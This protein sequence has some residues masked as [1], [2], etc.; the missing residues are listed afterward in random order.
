MDDSMIIDLYWRRDEEAITQTAQK[1]GS[2]CHGI[3]FNILHCHEDAEECVNDTY[4]HAWASIPPERPCRFKT[5]LGTVTRNL[6]INLWKKNHAQKRYDEFTVLLNELDDC[7]P[8][9]ES[10]EQTVDTKALGECID[11]WLSELPEADRH[12]FL[13]RYWY[14]ETV[15]TIARTKGLSANALTQKL[16]RMRSSLKRHLEKEG[17]EIS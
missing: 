3:S 2:Y 11:N 10:I 8:S 13:R 12:L 17:V 1:Y 4:E 16:F 7:V 15:S 9:R 6:A 5:W 14:G